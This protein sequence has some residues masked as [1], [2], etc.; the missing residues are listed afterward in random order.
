MNAVRNGDDSGEAVADWFENTYECSECGTTWTD[1]WSCTC[2]DRCPE[3]NVETD[4]SSSIDLSQPLTEEDY[5]G[6]ARL[7]ASLP[8]SGPIEVTVED[9]KAY[10]EAIL[11]GGEERFS[12]P[13]WEHVPR[14]EF[15]HTT[16]ICQPTDTTRP[17]DDLPEN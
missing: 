6:A 9:A 8:E 3:C 1:E 14:L 5:L 12:P 7:L 11:E 4:P 10:A 16:V 17:S 13:S 2:N 15:M